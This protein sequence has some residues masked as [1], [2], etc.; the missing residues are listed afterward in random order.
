MT[1]NLSEST[2][3]KSAPV[4]GQLEFKQSKAISIWFLV[5]SI[6][7]ILLFLET[8]GQGRPGYNVAVSITESALD[9]AE[10]FVDG[11]LRGQFNYI[12]EGKEGNSYACLYLK[13]AN[14]TH[15]LEL[16]KDGQPV[17]VKSIE[18]KG[19]EYVRFDSGGSQAGNRIK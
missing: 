16:K 15:M 4:A 2:G 17:R 7:L 18:I 3:N 9:G 8:Q 1:E 10:L 11:D 5:V 12:K 19:K 14:G 13:L 6:V